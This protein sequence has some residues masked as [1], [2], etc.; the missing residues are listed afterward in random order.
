M[1]EKEID[2]KWHGFADFIGIE[3]QTL[4]PHRI[5]ELLQDII[6]SGM[7]KY[8]DPTVLI[9]YL[10]VSILVSQLQLLYMT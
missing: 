7:L 3:D 2:D 10:D 8:A 4:T 1:K 9:S 6:D 5:K